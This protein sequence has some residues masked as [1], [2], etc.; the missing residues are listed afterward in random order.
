MVVLVQQCE[1]TSC[2]RTIH[3]K[4]AKSFVIYIFTAIK[5]KKEF[6]T[7]DQDPN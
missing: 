3:L 5:K 7:E 4:M 6:V 2:H 1:C